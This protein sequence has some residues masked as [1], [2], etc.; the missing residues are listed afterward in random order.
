MSA[1]ERAELAAEQF[2][3]LA[4]EAEMEQAVRDLIEIK[5][6]IVYHLRDARKAPELEGLP[7]LLVICPP[8]LAVIELKSAKRVITPKQALVNQ[9]LGDCS[10]LL[11]GV[12]RPWM[13]DALLEELA[14]L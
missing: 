11:T 7:D 2:R 6:G 4:T 12:Y 5:H 14:R 10:R 8:V 1:K 3:K 13:L 9:M